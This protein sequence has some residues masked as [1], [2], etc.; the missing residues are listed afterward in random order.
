MPLSANARASS[1]VNTV[2]LPSSLAPLASTLASKSG[3]RL[4][5]AAGIRA[6]RRRV[7]LVLAADVHRIVVAADVDAARRASRQNRHHVAQIDLPRDAALRRNDVRVEIDAQLLARAAHLLEDPVARGADAARRRFLI[8]ERVARAEAHQPGQQLLQ[9][10][11]RHRRDDLFDSRIRVRP[12]RALRAGQRRQ[13]DHHCNCKP[14]SHHRRV[15]FFLAF[16]F[17]NCHDISNK[18]RSASG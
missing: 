5:I 11:L 16:E 18:S 7:R 6:R 14:S 4:P 10:L 1:I 13:R 3:T 17:M 15:L 2:P 9:P 8:G 12:W